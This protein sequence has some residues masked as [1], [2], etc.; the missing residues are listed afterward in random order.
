MK[1][2]VKNLQEQG[3]CQGSFAGLW[4]LW[5][6][7]H[8]MSN[9]C[10]VIPSC[11]SLKNCPTDSHSN[12]FGW[13]VHGIFQMVT[14]SKYSSQSL[15]LESYQSPFVLPANAL[16]SDASTPTQA[17]RH[18]QRRRQVPVV[19]LAHL[20]CLNISPDLGVVKTALRGRWIGRD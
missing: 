15:K 20:K 8:K 7:M 18:D 9:E 3:Q 5:S 12:A 13:E 14:T 16:A 19:T 10:S 1:L 17:G 6:F 2:I 11:I 4:L